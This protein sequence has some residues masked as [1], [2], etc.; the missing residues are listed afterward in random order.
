M[1]SEGFCIITVTCTVV[2]LTSDSVGVE[3]AMVEPCQWWPRSLTC[4]LAEERTMEAAIH[5]YYNLKISF[6]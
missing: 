1:L 3:V 4:C 5:Y 2:E 6:R